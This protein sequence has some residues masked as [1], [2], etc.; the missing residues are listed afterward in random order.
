MGHVRDGKASKMLDARIALPRAHGIA[1]ILY[2]AMLVQEEPV[3]FKHSEIRE[4]S[5]RVR[6]RFFLSIENR[7]SVK[8]FCPKP[9]STTVI[10]PPYVD[11][12]KRSLLAYIPG[13]HSYHLMRA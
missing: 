11:P 3:V 8:L 7:V 6:L 2:Q 12:R 1:Y 13:M 4:C 5:E 9:K 10:F